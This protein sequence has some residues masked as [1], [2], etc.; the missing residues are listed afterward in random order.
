MKAYITLLST[1]QYLD[2]VL[3]LN[4]SL[5]DTGAKYPLVVG[6][7]S[8]IYPEVRNI[9]FQKKLQIIELQDFSYRADCKTNFIARGMPHWY[10]TA[11]K[12]RIFGLTEFEKLV[13][14]DSDMLVLKNLDHLF[15]CPDGSASED[16]P[17][18]HSENRSS[19]YQLNS[20]LL[21]I[22]PSK[23]KEKKLIE[24]SN[25]HNAAD[26][27]LIRMLYS[28]WVDKKELHLPDTY[29][30]FNS[31]ISKYQKAGLKIEDFMVIHFIGKIK[32]FMKINENY[33]L[34]NFSEYF[35]N[36]YIS[37][38]TRAQKGLTYL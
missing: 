18:T 26:Q 27:D 12:I 33:S 4:Q 24:L 8:D 19:H 3:T 30:I 10:H 7:T 25:V 9:L 16:S 2:G 6:V 22:E 17:M 38:L 14:L 36:I 35:E 20:G 37:T 21:V 5:I 28:D 34:K 23:E 15:D 13:Y 11:A 31:Q 1:N 29:N 32:P